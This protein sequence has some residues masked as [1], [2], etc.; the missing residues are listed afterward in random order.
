MR[1]DASKALA[2]PPDHPQFPS[3]MWLLRQPPQMHVLWSAAALGTSQ[4]ICH[5]YVILVFSVTPA[6][7]PAQRWWATMRNH[8]ASKR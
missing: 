1:M 3:Q 6:T 5:V 2:S 4:Y 7:D 8:H